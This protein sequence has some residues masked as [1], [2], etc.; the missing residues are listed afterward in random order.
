MARR[1]YLAGAVLLLVFGAGTLVGWRARS[2]RETE[3]GRTVA[4][5]RDL[6]IAGLCANGLREIETGRQGTAARMLEWRMNAAMADAGG[7]LIA[8]PGASRSRPTLV[9]GLRRA[10]G[11]ARGREMGGVMTECQRALEVLAAA[12]AN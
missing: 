9:E 2:A 10:Q 7:L 11:Y 5:V 8:A 1:S 6:E 3:R 12:R 4:L